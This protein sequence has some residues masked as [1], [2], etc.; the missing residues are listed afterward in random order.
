MIISVDFK[1]F[2]ASVN[3]Q[4]SKEHDSVTNRVAGFICKHVFTEHRSCVTGLAA[5]GREAGYN[6]TYLVSSWI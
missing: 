6:T 1:Y 5:V 2:F 4:G 3:L